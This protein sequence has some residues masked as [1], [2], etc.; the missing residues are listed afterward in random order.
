MPKRTDIHSVLIIGAG[1]IISAKSLRSDYSGDT[2][3]QGPEGGRLPRGAGEFQPGDHRC[4]TRYLAD[5]TYI[6][7]VTPEC[8]EKI[9][10]R[11]AGGDEERMGAQGKL[12]LLPDAGRADGQNT[13]MALHRNGALER[14]GIEMIGAN[15]G[16]PSSAGVSA[17]QIF[18]EHMLK[19]GLDVPISGTAHNVAEA[20]AVAERIG[21]FPLII[22]PPTRWAA[23]SEGIAYNRD[24]FEELAKRGIELSPVS[25]SWWRNRCWAGRNTRWRSCTQAPPDNC[26]IIC[27][28]REY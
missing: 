22:G 4:W 8:V 10:K 2:S 9:I 21:K 17:R 19:I 12:V 18:K 1:P 26:V 6:E 24:E 16:R 23:R 11:G 13:A 5:R 27:S 3:V 28:D 7:P 25:K 20:R 15:S 14:H